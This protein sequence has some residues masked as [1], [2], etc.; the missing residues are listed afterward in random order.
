MFGPST[1]PIPNVKLSELA[2]TARWCIRLG[3]TEYFVPAVQPGILSRFATAYP[4]VQLE[5]RMDLSH[6]LRKELAAGRL[7]AG[8]VKLAQHERGRAI[9]SEGQV[10]V[11]P[12]G[13]AADRAKPVPLALLPP[14]RGLRRHAL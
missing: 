3:I 6:V 7:D 8:I 13:W 9:W 10:W 1:A 14:P 2:A 4:G 5:A 11:A 12:Q